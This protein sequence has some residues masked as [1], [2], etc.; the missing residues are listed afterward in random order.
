[1]TPTSA[2]ALADLVACPAQSSTFT[3]AASGS[4]PFS[5]VWRKNGAVI[6]GA[7]ANM[8]TIAHDSMSDAGTYTVEV[9]G[10]CTSVTNSAT[11]TVVDTAATPLTSTTVCPGQSATFSTVAS[12]GGPFTY[13]WRKN[14]IVQ[15]S[16]SNSLT[17][18]SAATSDPGTYSVEVTGTCNTVT[19][20]ATLTVNHLA[21]ATPLTNKLATAGQ[22]VAF[23]TVASGTGPFSYLWSKDGQ[24]LTNQTDDHITLSNLVIADS[25]TYSV[26]VSGNCNVTN[27]SA[28][29]SVG[30][31]PAL[32]GVPADT[33]ANCDAVPIAATPSATGGCNGAP[34]IAYIEV[35]TPGSCTN[36]YTLLRTWTA[37]DSCNSS[38]SASQTITV[39][40]ITAPALVGVPADTTVACDQIPAAPTVSAIDGCDTN[41]S[42]TLTEA[43]TGNGCGHDDYTITRTW[44]ASD[45]CG[46]TS[47]QVQHLSVIDVA[48]HIVTGPTSQTLAAGDLLNLS[49]SANGTN[50]NYQWTHNGTNIADATNDTLLVTNALRANAGTYTAV[51]SGIST[52]NSDP[53]SVIVI[54]PVITNQ[55]VSGNA[56]V[57][58]KF[59]LSVGATGTPIPGFATGLHFQWYFQRFGG[60]TARPMHGRTNVVLRFNP[61]DVTNAGSY[62]CVVTNRFLPGEIVT[63]NGNIVT[64]AV[65]TVTT[66]SAPTIN[67]QPTNIVRTVGNNAP[68]VVGAVGGAPF[69]YQWN[70]NGVAIPGAQKSAYT[71]YNVQ[72]SDA[73]TYTCTVTKSIGGV[74]ASAQTST[75]K[76]HLVVNGDS[77]TPVSFITYP[78]TATSLSYGAVRTNGTLTATAPDTII[79]GRA[80]DDGW[81]T[82]ITLIRTFPPWA[83]ESQWDVTLQGQLPNRQTWATNVTLVDGTNI[84]VATATD[85]TGK[86]GQ[87]N[88]RLIFLRDRAPL[89]VNVNGSGRT[90]PVTTNAVPPKNGAMLDVNR[91]YTIKAVPSNSVQ[92]VNWTDG[93]GTILSNGPTLQFIMTNGLILNANFNH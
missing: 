84:F 70:F 8:Y 22:T 1:S 89:T 76:G 42:V 60:S 43:S 78:A 58:S 11:L 25:G 17:I 92:F 49:V 62:F 75:N 81:I 68:F 80:I 57:G 19:N 5:Y 28:T 87:S 20:A 55:P 63:P 79:G 50:L 4:G 45:V 26:Q 93:S 59:S 38:T 23:M 72:L 33:T 90:S 74:L 10:A 31:V 61:M 83:T 47:T 13:V 51:V 27:Q 64:S 82:N 44:T 36:R 88:P 65:A 2:T 91:G 21:D 39:V 34:I 18:V 3:T 85:D 14:G 56:P 66:F 46:N 71:R 16:T 29:L 35:K 73:G 15:S 37:T 9:Y 32:I 67:S 86:T 6:V 7:S 54:D 40:D 53:A 30:P 41:P 48:P 12:G 52:T 24:E 77:K 69:T